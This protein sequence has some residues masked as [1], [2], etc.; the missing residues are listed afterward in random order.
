MELLKKRVETDIAK[1]V[2]PTAKETIFQVQGNITKLHFCY[3]G[4]AA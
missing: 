4:S 2:A 3:E 1:W